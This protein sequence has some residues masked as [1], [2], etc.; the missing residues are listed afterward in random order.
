MAKR[1]IAIVILVPVA[2]ILIAFLVA[3]RHSVSLTLDPFHPGDPALSYSAPFFV[4]LFAAF[5]LGLVVGGFA[6][7]L[8]QGR[9]RRLARQRGKEAERLRQDVEDAERRRRETEAAHAFSPAE[10][11]AGLPAPR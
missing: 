8:G 2:I 10:G 7:W 11:G 5:V 9:H 1:I 4:W 6:V 3:N